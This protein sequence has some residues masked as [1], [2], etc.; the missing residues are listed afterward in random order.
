[1]MSIEQEYSVTAHVSELT[2][3]IPISMLKQNGELNYVDV[4]SIVSEKQRVMLGIWFLVDKVD[5]P[6]WA[7]I[8]KLNLFLTRS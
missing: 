8:L 3:D 7:P 2:P 5:A 4:V 1:M 6:R